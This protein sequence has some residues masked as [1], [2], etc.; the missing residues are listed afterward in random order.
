MV[1]KLP[2]LSDIFA[3]RLKQLREG[4]G[5]SKVDLAEK[6]GVSDNQIRRWE[7]G[8][9]RPRPEKE[10]LLAEIFQIN[11]IDLYIPKGAAEKPEALIPEIQGALNKDLSSLV[12]RLLNE[13]EQF[14]KQIESL[15]SENKE[16]KS[17]LTKKDDRD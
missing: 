4:A 1:I 15:T 3:K 8:T 16:L 6:L 10:D 11:P 13:R 5:L 14:E 2:I 9:A 12:R 7:S 17:H